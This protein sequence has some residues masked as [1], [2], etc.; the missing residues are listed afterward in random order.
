[1]RLSESGFR[2]SVSVAGIYL[3]RGE[4]DSTFYWLEKSY[5][6]RESTLPWI[7]S[8]PSFDGIRSG[9]RYIELVEKMGLEP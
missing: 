3:A 9:P 8:R 2:A 6:N 4:R 7:R 5:E 1:M